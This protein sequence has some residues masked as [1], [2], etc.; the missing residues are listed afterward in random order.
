MKKRK[1]I[2]RISDDEVNLLKIDKNKIEAFKSIE[3]KSKF[4]LRMKKRNVSIILEGEEIFIKYFT[5]PSYCKNKLREVI[6]NK[7][8]SLYGS[9]VDN[10]LFSYSVIDEEDAQ[11]STIVY[12][13]NSSNLEKN[14]E[15]IFNNNIVSSVS[16]IQYYFL[17][18]YDASF[19]HNRFVFAFKF[20]EIFYIMFV[21]NKNILVNFAFNELEENNRL[22]FDFIKNTA[23]ENYEDNYDSIAI[24]RSNF[25]IDEKDLPS[26]YKYD[27]V[28]LDNVDEKILYLEME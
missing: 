6:K 5:F 9:N 11:L 8:I 15:I 13:I 22:L 1:Y 2:I 18:Y 23:I 20:N 19:I 21:K 14:K 25:D 7:L 26:K 16:L 24:Y 10:I 28:K 27:I 12:C 3:G 17:K 4:K